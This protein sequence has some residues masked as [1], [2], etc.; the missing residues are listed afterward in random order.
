M[1]LQ[2]SNCGLRLT[3]SLYP[4]AHIWDFRFA[5]GSSQLPCLFWDC[6][7][8]RCKTYLWSVVYP[9]KREPQTGNLTARA[10]SRD[11]LTFAIRRKRRK[12]STLWS[13]L[14][15]NIDS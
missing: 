3:V 5:G 8:L 13:L 15:S 2:T 6:D 10:W 12:T 14:F 7:V 9:Y 4:S 1:L 11:F